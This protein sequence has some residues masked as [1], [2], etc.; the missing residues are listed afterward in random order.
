MSSLVQSL[1]AV[2]RFRE[3]VLL[4]VERDLKARYKRSV[5]GMFWSLLNPLL[6]MAVLSVVFSVIMRV[7]LPAFPLFLLAGLLPWTLVSV[8]ITAASVSLLNNQGLIRKVAVPQMV[9]PLAIVG[10]KLVDTLLSLVPLAIIATAFGRPPGLSWIFLPA[11]LVLVTLFTVGMAVLFSSLTVFYRDMRHLT[12]ILMQVWFYLTPIFYPVD[13]L[14]NLPY[15]W[16]KYALLA[17]PAAPLVE[18]FHASVYQGTFPSAEAIA[19]ATAT[20]L[21]SMA[22]GLFVFLRR[23]HEHINAF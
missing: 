20:A 8:S 15:P 21:G 9:Y 18:V 2:V 23:Q 12:E 3:L 11:A 13:Y 17:N 22:L 16:L 1:R 4:L 14:L 7:D 5:L 19:W 6:Q 10:S